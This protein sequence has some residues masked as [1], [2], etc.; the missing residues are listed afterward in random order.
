LPIYLD[1]V[2]AEAV[3]DQAELPPELKARHAPG[4]R[5]NAKPTVNTRSIQPLSIAGKPT[6]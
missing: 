2:V 5:P 1:L 6:K 3:F 4:L